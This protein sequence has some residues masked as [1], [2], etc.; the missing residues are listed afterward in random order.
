MTKDM[1]EQN[2]STM[3]GTDAR[4]ALNELGGS[5]NAAVKGAKNFFGG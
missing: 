3:K 2:V 1:M 4:R 5:T